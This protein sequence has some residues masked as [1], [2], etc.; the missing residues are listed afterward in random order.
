MKMHTFSNPTPYSKPYANHPFEAHGCD[1]IETFRAV[2]GGDFCALQEGQAA[3][4]PGF[5]PWRCADGRIV[6][7]QA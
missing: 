7:V 2:N 6:G 5:R 1:S 3:C 4:Q